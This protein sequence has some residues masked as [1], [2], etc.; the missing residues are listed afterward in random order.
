[1][2]GGV[3]TSKGADVDAKELNDLCGPL[4]EAWPECRPAE[5][6]R[7]LGFYAPPGCGLMP[8]WFYVS[9]G[10]DVVWTQ[11]AR[12]AA[13]LIRVEIEDALRGEV[14]RLTLCNR[15]ADAE[16]TEAVLLGAAGDQREHGGPTLLHALVTAA[17]AVADARK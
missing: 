8:F 11:S 2:G 10:G 12:H 13:A 7:Q 5:D 14:G 16:N 1:M 4:F 6:E 3:R 17:L 15:D 9:A